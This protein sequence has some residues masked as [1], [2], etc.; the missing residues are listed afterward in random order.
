MPLILAIGAIATAAGTKLLGPWL[1]NGTNQ[2]A[3]VAGALLVIWLGSAA[4]YYFVTAI[5]TRRALDRRA[6][7]LETVLEN[8]SHGLATF[9]AQ[10]ELQLWNNRFIAMYGL[11][12]GEFRRGMTLREV[13]VIKKRLNMFQGDIDAYLADMDIRAAKE[14]AA[15][16]VFTLPNGKSISVTRQMMADGGWVALH[17]DISTQVDL[18]KKLDESNR[19]LNYVIDH[20]PSSVVVKRV[21]DSKYLLVNRAF[22]TNTGLKRADV[23]GKTAESFYSPDMVEFITETE[24]KAMAEGGVYS[25]ERATVNPNGDRRMS[26]VS[27]FVTR[28]GEGKPEYMIG[29]V[30]DLTSIY[31]I[32]D[33]LKKTKTFLASVIENI[34]LNVVVKDVKNLSY[35]L[36]NSAWENYMGL[37]RADVLGKTA[38][39]LMPADVA[40]LL[41]A[42][43][44]AAIE[45]NDGK[46][47]ERARVYKNGDV[48]H[49]RILRIMTRDKDGNPEHLIAIVEDVTEGRV[50]A[51][52]LEDTKK[53]LEAVVDNIPTSLAVHD[54][55]NER[56]LLVN[57]EG[58]EMLDWHRDSLVGKTLSEVYPEGQIDIVRARHRE[59][60]ARNGE[61]VSGIYPFQHPTKGMR[62]LAE[63]RVA[64]ADEAGQPKYVILSGED[65]TERRQAESRI[66]HMAFHDT[67]TDLPNRAAFN[68]SL[69]QMIEA[70]SDHHTQFAILSVDLVRFKEINDVCGHDVGDMLLKQVGVALQ[71]AAAGAVI[72]RLSGD[73]FGLI[74][75][76]P[77]PAAGIALAEKISAALSKEFIID[78]KA[79]HIGATCGIA[80]FPSD[81][82]TPAALMANADAALHRA[83]SEA[84]GSMR[85]FDA[86]MDQQIRDRR[87]LNRDL[88]D[89]IKAGQ[90]E[91]HYQPQAVMP[92]RIVGFEALIRWNHPTR[93]F[94]PPGL[95][96]PIAEESSLIVE[97][98][99]WVL[100]EACREA[101][102]W[103]IP[104]QIAVNLS[105]IQ[106]LHGDLVERVHQI[107]FETGLQASRLE[108]EITEGVLIRDFERGLSLLR[109]L[110]ALG[111]RIA[112]DDFGSGYSSLSYLQSFPFDKIKID[113]AFITNLGRNPQSAAIVRA[114]I[115]LGHGL[116]VPIVAEGVETQEQLKFLIEESCDQVQGYFI[117]KPAPITTYNDVVGRKAA[118]RAV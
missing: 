82:E 12:A 39:D 16:A 99:D 101:A 72:A 42:E 81:G 58:A 64:I 20:I 32:A 107:L 62:M 4:L 116:H 104:L 1:S 95:F 23:I 97:M 106:F 10:G 109:R 91:L 31:T 103:P 93:G 24:R 59:A 100:R 113:R 86:S 26:R 34:P 46:V 94:I 80:V 92:H 11:D 13:L 111:V 27:R 14:G 45:T 66:A 105:P 41:N 52:E 51:R 110:K 60:L 114:V 43:E 55:K 37:K 49:Q 54:V 28:D 77:Q 102:S 17:E 79:H 53:F 18:T 115:G 9:N 87:A 19:F 8:M 38:S 3:D 36:V 15:Q 22:E 75:D 98:G 88:G 47:V 48:R 2:V 44:R 7:Q 90:L 89:A 63:R 118:L 5:D 84:R 78:G 21:K 70:C 61:V 56:Y 74:V 40:E 68:Q 30:D 25:T 67:L 33:D 71:G 85:V 73:E 35:L 108:L 57:R 96:I 65:V 6:T 112:M 69:A 83:K 76:G 117:G 50:L 29:I